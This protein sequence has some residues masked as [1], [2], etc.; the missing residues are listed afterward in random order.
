MLY[1]SNCNC[2]LI[3][4]ESTSISTQTDPIFDFCSVSDVKKEFAENGCVSIFAASKL[5]VKIKCEEIEDLLI[6]DCGD[7]LME[8]DLST[9]VD[10]GKFS[11]TDN[12]SDAALAPRRKSKSKD[13][14]ETCSSSESSAKLIKT[15]KKKD[16]SV[17]KD[18]LKKKKNNLWICCVCIKKCYKKNEI[19]KHYKYD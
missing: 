1:G 17:K 15:S 4:N 18:P 7:A 3:K 5:E 2:K 19:I 9:A 10:S 14:S 13:K 11:L 6:D 8:S 12:D 16:S